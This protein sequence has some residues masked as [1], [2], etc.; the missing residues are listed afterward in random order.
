MRH[1]LARWPAHRPGPLL[2]RHRARCLAGGAG[3]CRA[4][5]SRPLAAGPDSG[6]RSLHAGRG[7]GPGPGGGPAGGAESAA[8]APLLTQ[9]PACAA[10]PP[11][12][13][14]NQVVEPSA[15]GYGPSAMHWHDFCAQRD[16]AMPCFQ[17]LLP[18]TVLQRRRA[19]AAAHGFGTPPTQRSSPSTEPFTMWNV[20]WD[21]VDAGVPLCRGGDWEEL[22]APWWWPLKQHSSRAPPAGPAAADVGPAV[23]SSCEALALL[24]A[25]A[26]LL[27][28]CPLRLSPCPRPGR[29]AAVQLQQQAW[30][31]YLLIAGGCPRTAACSTLQHHGRD[32]QHGTTTAV[33]PEPDI[34]RDWNPQDSDDDCELRG[35]SSSDE[36]AGSP[37]QQLSFPMPAAAPAA[38][39]HRYA[40]VRLHILPAP[41]ASFSA[42]RLA[43]ALLPAGFFELLAA[44]LL[45]LRAS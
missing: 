13:R 17:L 38:A 6:G 19:P 21:L 3:L 37:R 43:P 32:F 34:H 10:A 42:M 31:P 5:G 30:R 28:P 20:Q 33:R 12:T 2:L 27:M 4:A 9:L 1:P 16:A 40:D 24:S 7:A 35:F 39:N 45:D 29:R 25:L 26:P 44:Q 15:P 11:P 14:P 22:L 41:S 18:R 36:A 8:G 23:R